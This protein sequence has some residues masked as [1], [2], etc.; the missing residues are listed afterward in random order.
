MRTMGA[1]GEGAKGACHLGPQGWGAS[2]LGFWVIFCKYLSLPPQGFT[3][4]GAYGTCWLRLTPYYQ[5][6]Y[7]LPHYEVIIKISNCQI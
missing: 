7:L 5:Y 1:K 2:P 6:I 3:S 4:F